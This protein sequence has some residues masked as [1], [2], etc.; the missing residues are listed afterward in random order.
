MKRQNPATVAPGRSRSAGSLRFAGARSNR[1]LLPPVMI[2][3]FGRGCK[4]QAEIQPSAPGR[5]GPPRPASTNRFSLRR[6]GWVSY[7]GLAPPERWRGCFQVAGFRLTLTAQAGAEQPRRAERCRLTSVVPMEKGERRWVCCRAMLVF[8]AATVERRRAR[9]L[10]A[11]LGQAVQ[12]RHLEQEGQVLSQ[13][14]VLGEER[15]ANDWHHV[16]GSFP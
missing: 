13:A 7:R 14:E 8:P 2:R 16:W 3:N 6:K 9:T 15:S 10:P 5:E 11:S 1:R 12:D 4:I